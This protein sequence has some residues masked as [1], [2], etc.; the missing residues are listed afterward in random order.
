MD[1]TLTLSDLVGI[2]FKIGRY[3]LK[4][5]DCRG[6]CYLYY[7]YI[8]KIEIPHTDGKR[9][10]FH[11]S[12]KDN[13]RIDVVLK[14]FCDEIDLDDIQEGDL[15]SMKFNKRFFSLSVCIS[16]D[17]ILYTTKKYGSCIGK[18]ELLKRL[19]NK[20]YRPRN[21]KVI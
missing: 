19:F 12:K 15:I 8:K 10:W 2:P 4:A 18:K 6:I 3:D 17:K 20:V 13:E 21:E 14:T 16:R 5:A 1:K 9:V 7:K 11:N